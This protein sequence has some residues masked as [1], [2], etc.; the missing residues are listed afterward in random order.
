MRGIQKGDLSFDFY[1]RKPRRE[2]I[3]LGKK[4]IPSREGIFWSIFQYSSCPRLL[5]EGADG[6]GGNP[7]LHPVDALCLEIDREGA[8]SLD[9]R[10]AAIVAGLGAS[11]G[12]LACSAHKRTFQLLGNKRESIMDRQE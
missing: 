12:H 10:V 5:R 4:K 8:T 2:A 3:T 6:L 7:E 11:S 9:I 1:G